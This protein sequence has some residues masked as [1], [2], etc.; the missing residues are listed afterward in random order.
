LGL[1]LLLATGAY[2]LLPK[3]M[4]STED[5]AFAGTLAAMGG[6]CL[7]SRSLPDRPVRS[8]FLL[9]IG[10]LALVWIR[11][12]RL[13]QMGFGSA[14]WRLA[15]Y[16]QLLGGWLQFFNAYGVFGSAIALREDPT[17]RWYR[18]V[19]FGS[20]CCGI[21]GIILSSVYRVMNFVSYRKLIM[22]RASVD[23]IGTVNLAGDLIVFMCSILVLLPAREDDHRRR[24]DLVWKGMIAWAAIIVALR[25]LHAG[26]I[27]VMP[28]DYVGK[29]WQIAF[30]FACMTGVLHLLN[31]VL[32][33]F[34]I[35]KSPS[36]YNSAT[37][38]H[39]QSGAGA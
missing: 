19:S 7:F 15:Y 35:K 39:P 38:P 30:W 34:A 16:A 2:F 21:A 31:P 8:R 27:L 13:H 24:D 18:R 11:L 25:I 12:M 36:G 17:N 14:S 23:L 3:Y 28:V 37:A 6:L 20:A 29:E 1:L 32:L 26:A 5:G 9:G 22:M 33:S 10:L 4:A